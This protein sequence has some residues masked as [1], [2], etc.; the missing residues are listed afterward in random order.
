MNTEIYE[1]RS[2][3][4]TLQKILAIVM[5]F[6]LTAMIVTGLTS[7]V[8]AQAGPADI[9]LPSDVESL[10]AD[11]GDGM[12]SLSWDVATD[13]VGVEG[14]KVYYGTS[15]VTA[16]GGS[17][18]FTLEVGD[19]IE[20]DVENLDNDT[21]YYFAATAYDASG[22]ESESYSFEVHAIPQK[23][24]EVEEVVVPMGDDGKA[25]T[26]KSTESYSNVQIKVT[27]SEAVV[28]PEEEPQ[29]AF[30]IKD[31]L[32]GEYLPL[33]DAE[34]LNSDKKVVILE[35]APQDSSTEYILTAGITIED[36]YGHSIRSG[37]SDTATFVGGEGAYKPVNVD[38]A[39]EI[40]EDVV[41]DSGLGE[42]VTDVV[43]EEALDSL[44]G[45]L[46][47]AS[48]SLF[49]DLSPEEMAAL[50]AAL[51]AAVEEGDITGGVILEE[52]PMLPK[53][54]ESVEAVSENQLEVV[55]SDPVSFVEA[56]THF[57]VV[58]AIEDDPS[59]LEV[60]EGDILFI[61]AEELMEDS[62]TVSLMVDGMEPG[63]DYLLSILNVVTLA[64]S[65]AIDSGEGIA[66]QAPTLEL[67]DIIPPE[68]IT[69]LMSNLTGAL[70]TLTWN[71]SISEDAIEQVVYESMDGAS[72]S[73][74]VVLPPLVTE[75]EIND[76]MA[77]MTY[78]FKV[79]SKDAAG[80]ESEGVVVQVTLPETGPGLALMFGISLLGT[81]A[82]RRRKKGSL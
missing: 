10:Q 46:G 37:T 6:L 30:L 40:I 18:D 11:A 58:E 22:N 70:V 62:M 3:R 20:Y 35:T 28:L 1:Q 27:F 25:P 47:D 59:T 63:H 23:V 14:Y 75:F 21:E 2:A 49:G 34:I 69:N 52:A 7:M 56:E 73:E 41:A 64:S 80:N 71:V 45:G 60:E 81:A 79:T 44:S 67:V 17:Y 13:N 19:V 42:T 68:E 16:Q 76:L 15:S 65:E 8:F 50:E 5:G 77:G 32:T 43:V 51:E 66:F 26:V 24:E 57:M 31:N 55:F 72:Y 12:A 38:V 39:E 61:S 36:V 82:T 48:D 74:R 53:W 4:S 9:E 54:V 33:L 78:W 29:T